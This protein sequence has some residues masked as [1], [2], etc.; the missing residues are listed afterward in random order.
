MFNDVWYVN[1]H[2]Y[3]NTYELSQNVSINVNFS[4][5]SSL[6]LYVPAIADEDQKDGKMNDSYVNFPAAV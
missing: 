4:Y 6:Q 5:F 3:Y 1:C 2:L